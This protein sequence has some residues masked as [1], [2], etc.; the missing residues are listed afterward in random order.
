MS[1]LEAILT[2]MKNEPAFADSVFADAAR[3]LAE[4]RLPAEFIARLKAVPRAQFEAQPIEELKTLWVAA[5]ARR[6]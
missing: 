4:Y 2:R 1:P 3:A 5:D 6:G